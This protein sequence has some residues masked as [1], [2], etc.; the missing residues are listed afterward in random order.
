MKDSIDLFRHAGPPTMRERRRWARSVEKLVADAHRYI[1]L[2][3][4]R[5]LYN[6]AAVRRATPALLDIA[7]ALRAEDL[8]V[9]R[10]LLG[11]LRALLTDGGSSPLYR[12]HP[13]AALWAI[14][15][16]RHRLLPE[17]PLHRQAA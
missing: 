16:L 4:Y 1:L 10:E 2:R 15:D 12:D 3:A 14:E 17:P 7:A 5:P 8:E 9:S 13:I 11:E 6:T